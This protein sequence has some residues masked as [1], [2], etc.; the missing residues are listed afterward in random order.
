MLVTLSVNSGTLSATA[1]SSTLS[2]A[3]TGTMTL[4]GTVAQIN[5]A[6]ASV[7]YNRTTGGSATLTMTT[8]DQLGTVTSTDVDTSTITVAAPTVAITSATATTQSTVTDSFGGLAAQVSYSAPITSATT[9]LWNVAVPEGLYVTG[10]AGTSAT[11]N[12]VIS[13]SSLELNTW[14]GSTATNTTMTFTTRGGASFSGIS[15][16]TAWGDV[17]RAPSTPVVVK[18]YNASNTEIHSASFRFDQVTTKYGTYSFNTSF[19]GQAT[20]FTIS[21]VGVNAFAMDDLAYTTTAGATP[22]TVVSGGAMLDT[23]PSWTG[24]ISRPLATGETVEVLRDGVV[25]GNATIS[26]GGS[27]WT[28][29]DPTAASVTTHSYTARLKSSGGTALATS[30]AFSLKIAATP[31]VLDLNG[32]GVQT[33]SITEGTQFDLLA[34][35]AKQNLGWVSQQDGLLAIDLNGDG[36]INSGAELFGDR[37]VLADGS[38]AV[39]GWAALRGMDSNHDGKVDAQD[40]QFN[41]LRVWVDA[42]SDGVT[43]AGEL[44]SLADQGIASID[45]AADGRS[46]QQNGNVVQAFS[47][48]TTTDGVTHEVAD[49]GFAVSQPAGVYSL[50]NGAHFDWSAVADAA[51]THIDMVSDTAANTLKLSL[52]DVLGVPAT[53]GVHKLTVTAGANDTVDLDFSEWTSAGTSVTEGGHTYAVYNGNTDAAAQLLIDQTL[54]NAGHLV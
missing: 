42:D 24:T 1:G 14:G 26:V 2:G 27:T 16:L 50:Q 40:A 44:R 43:D 9:A 35:G 7:T 5:S 46:V 15:F 31:L 13:G 20:K 48:Y 37:T 41:Q 49:V 22:Y 8:S 39:D 25:M 54:V 3:G 53:D 45:L 32:D 38:R 21:T 4:A 11:G 47:T 28:Y 52:S 10:D 18:F 33:T 30:A 23:T 36:Q 51:P 6:L 19:T 29:T 34:I 17:L 12:W